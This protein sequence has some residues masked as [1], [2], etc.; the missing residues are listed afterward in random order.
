MILTYTINAKYKNNLNG[1]AIFEHLIKLKEGR[2]ES[3]KKKEGETRNVIECEIY[4][5][6]RG[7]ILQ[8][9]TDI[10]SISIRP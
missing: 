10:D 9:E 2:R 4:T 1:I 8:S 3:I 7:V 5:E 6:I